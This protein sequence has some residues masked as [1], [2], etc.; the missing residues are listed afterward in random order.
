MTVIGWDHISNRRKCAWQIVQFAVVIQEQDRSTCRKWMAAVILPP[1]HQASLKPSERAIIKPCSV[2]LPA[3]THSTPHQHDAQSL[4][5][6][7]RGSTISLTSQPTE[8][9]R[10]HLPNG[11]QPKTGTKREQ[12]DPELM[13]RAG[14]A[15]FRTFRSCFAA[16]IYCTSLPVYNYSTTGTL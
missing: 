14:N 6:V 7:R 10:R 3:T 2:S 12:N 13:P 1:R 5:K 15:S 4:S 8:V 9:D 11:K 16:C